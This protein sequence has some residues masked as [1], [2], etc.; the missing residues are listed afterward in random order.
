MR[1]ASIITYLLKCA[2]VCVSQPVPEYRFGAGISE[3]CKGSRV[4]SE[5]QGEQRQDRGWAGETASAEAT[6]PESK[7]KDPG[8]EALGN[9]QTRSQGTLST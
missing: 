6:E 4:R 3:Q 2:R 8:V 5:V 9:P 1:E 7:A